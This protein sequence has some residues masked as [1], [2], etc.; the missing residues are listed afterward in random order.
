MQPEHGSPWGCSWSLRPCGRLWN[1]PFGGWFPRA[2][3]HSASWILTT[4]ETTV[5]KWKSHLTS[6]LVKAWKIQGSFY[7]AYIKNVTGNAVGFRIHYGDHTSDLL[8]KE[9]FQSSLSR[10]QFGISLRRTHC[11]TRFWNSRAW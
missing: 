10:L 5:G 7:F 9:T 1:R 2:P 3:P 6:F 8:P 11:W 4:H